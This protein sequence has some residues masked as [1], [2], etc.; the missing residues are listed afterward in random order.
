MKKKKIEEGKLPNTFYKAN[1][2]LIASQ[3]KTPQKK[4]TMGQ[5]P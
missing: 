1:I 4:K 2:T 3:A 5:Y